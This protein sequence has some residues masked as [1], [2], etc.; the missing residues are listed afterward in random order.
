MLMFKRHKDKMNLQCKR[1]INKSYIVS[2]LSFLK[3]RS[4]PK[5]PLLFPVQKPV[6]LFTLRL[7]FLQAPQSTSVDNEPIIVIFLMC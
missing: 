1:K 6:L 4:E 2:C 5:T 7:I 3:N